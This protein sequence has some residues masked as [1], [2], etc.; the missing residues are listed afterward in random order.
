M[1]EFFDDEGPDLPDE[2]P[3][4]IT[5]PDGGACPKCKSTS[6]VVVGSG[7]VCNS[8]GNHFALAASGGE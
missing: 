5:S 4:P 1:D 8:C 3:V 6:T 2:V 7:V